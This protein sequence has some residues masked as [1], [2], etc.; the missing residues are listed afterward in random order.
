MNLFF[1]KSSLFVLSLVSIATV[2]AVLLRNKRKVSAR[3]CEE[4]DEP[5]LFI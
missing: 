4:S 5:V 3:V 2:T 1:F